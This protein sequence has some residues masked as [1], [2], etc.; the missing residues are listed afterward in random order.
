MA[1]KCSAWV[2]PAGFGDRTRRE[3]YDMQ[4]SWHPCANNA[5]GIRDGKPVC[6]RHLKSS[7]FEPAPYQLRKKTS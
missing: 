1:I 7:V 2:P 3:A 6:R 5:S 4:S